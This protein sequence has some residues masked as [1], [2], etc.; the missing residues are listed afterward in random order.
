[1]YILSMDFGSTNLKAIV[2]KIHNNDKETNIELVGKVRIKT[3]DFA[4]FI[5]E[6]IDK[7]KFSIDEIEKIVAT[8]T[9]SSFLDDKFRGIEIIKINEFHAIAYGGLL[10][11]NNEKGNIVSIGTGTTIVYSDMREIRRLGGTGLGGGALVGLGKAIL[12][13]ENDEN[14][15]L[16]NFDNLIFMAKSGNKNNVDLLIGDIS[17]ENIDNMTK[18]ITAADF[19]AL[20]KNAK[21]EDY[22]AATLNMILE[23]ISLLVNA[24]H[25]K[26]EPIIYIGTMVSD[27]Y[28]K[29]SL[30]KIAEYTGDDIQ[31]VENSEYAI[32]IG[33]WEYFLLNIGYHEK[34]IKY[35]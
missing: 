30:Q 28:V 8:G 32:A 17:K 29:R 19:A 12:S 23:N 10:L 16:A 18:D 35:D 1:M 22:I 33:A 31:F 9:G 26:G 5:S 24:L 13:K 34:L 14:N 11:S 3:T 6:I 15:E 2:L 25:K 4:L 21:P 7:Y 27:N 20:Y